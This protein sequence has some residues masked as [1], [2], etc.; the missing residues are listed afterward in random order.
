[1]KVAKD[2]SGTTFPLH[3]GQ[4]S[5]QPMPLSLMRTNPPKAMR[6]YVAAAAVHAR[7]LQ[8]R[9]GLDIDTGRLSRF[10]AMTGVGGPAPY[11]ADAG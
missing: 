2:M 6:K 10:R 1:M 5:P 7:R 3:S 9:K 11:G 4:S 8:D